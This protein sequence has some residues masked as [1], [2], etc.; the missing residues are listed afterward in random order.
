ME[1]YVPIA[2]VL[3]GFLCGAGLVWLALRGRIA[4]AER[5][6]RE[7]NQALADKA[8]QVARLE[9]KVSQTQELKVQLETSH[10]NYLQLGREKAAAE[11]DN[12]RLAAQLKSE[13]ARLQENLAVLDQA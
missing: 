2:A 12:A 3:A 8:L 11:N 9:E 13:Q 6:A 4:T 10:F 7:A 1:H 5:I